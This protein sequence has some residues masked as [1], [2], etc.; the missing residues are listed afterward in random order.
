M[1]DSKPLLTAERAR[2][3]FAYDPETGLVVR[4]VTVLKCKAGSRVGSPSKGYLNVCV[5]QRI[6]PLHRVIFLIVTGAWPTCEI[7]HRDGDKRNNRW[8]NL[9]D[10]P[11]ALNTQNKRVA[12][13]NNRQG[14]QGVG[15]SRGR[16]AASI[17]ADGRRRHLGTFDAP[18]E[19]HAAYLDAKRRLHAGCTI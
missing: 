4:R 19:A 16:F 13:R 9:R 2:E 6:Y 10:V 15:L 7:D 18:E 11:H 3:L 1:R 14:L 12:H 5:D 8:R 17:Q